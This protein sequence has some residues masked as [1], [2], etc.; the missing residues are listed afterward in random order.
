MKITISKKLFGGFFT[1]LFI[2]AVIIVIGYTQI[3]SVDYTYSNLIDD[4]ANKLIKMKELNV[5]IKEEQVGIR[6]Y[7]VVEDDKALE[8]FTEA[9]D[10]YLELSGDLF[11]S[12]TNSKNK[13]MLKE[14]DVLENE[15][16]QSAS[17]AI[18]LKQQNKTEEYT[19]LVKQGTLV[20]KLD[21]KIEELTIYEQSL[22]DEGY[23]TTTAK[24]ASVKTILVVLGII[25][26]LLGVTIAIYMGRIISKPVIVISETVKKIA[27]GDLTVDEIKVKNRDEIGE[28]A[29]SFNHMSRNL[30]ELIHQVGSNAEQVAASSEELTASS[31][32]TSQATE[33]IAEAMQEVVEGVDKQVNSVEET[34][35]T[36]KE[37]A[38]GIQQIAKNAQGVS[39]TAIDASEKALEGGQVLKNAIGQMYSI[40]ETVKEL[41]VVIKG[42]GERSKEID[43][44]IE[45]ITGI[46][47]QT[48]LL[49][50]NAAIEAARAG[51]HGRGFAVVADEVR[52]LAEQSA[53]SAQQ[54]SQLISTI[55]VETKKAVQSMEVATN[56]VISGIEVANMAGE[57]FEHIESSI[58]GVTNQLQEVSSAV[59]QIAAG[60]EQISQSMKLITEVSEST[61][62]GTQG[63]SAATEEQLASMEEIASSSNALSKMAAELQMLIG[64]FKI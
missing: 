23:K 51:D 63:V 7:L 3:L 62:S 24:V 20:K 46:A 9:H 10:K 54:I 47:A 2:L 39:S 5:L 44:I 18:L 16:F 33:H 34:S 50:L 48:N 37:M 41:S 45:V 43:Q 28:L 60:S 36:I 40:N 14:L 25:A 1:I 11:T 8:S 56:E 57:S 19:S 13:E 64:K 12:F 53:Q 15:Y 38:I 52:K 61:A 30:R 22:V 32:Q 4:S 6:G 59:Q 17:K 27:N 31:E 55:Q 21:E 42:L 26:I 35:Q 58:T 49:A 29:N